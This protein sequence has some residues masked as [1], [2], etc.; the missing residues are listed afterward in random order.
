M[1]NR[2]G[3]LLA[4]SIREAVACQAKKH[5]SCNVHA[6]CGPTFKQWAARVTLNAQ[7]P[8]VTFTTEP[9]GKGQARI[10]FLMVK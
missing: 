7:W 1:H 3:V 2:Y 6:C 5:A 10:P 9:S 4:L 8:S